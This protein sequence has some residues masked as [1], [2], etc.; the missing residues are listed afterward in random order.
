M[1][2]GVNDVAGAHAHAQHLDLAAE[3]N[4][5][6]VSMRRP[7]HRREE[8][9]A[10]RPDVDVAHRAVGDHAERTQAEVNRRLDFAPERAV[11]GVGPVEILD[12][13]QRRFGAVVD[14]AIIV[15]PQIA[16]LGRAQ[17]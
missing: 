16:R 1:T 12:Q 10:G 4:D 7:D 3:V 2:V 5:A 6:D 14:V 13:H 11:P 8:L 17:R 9:E 15:V